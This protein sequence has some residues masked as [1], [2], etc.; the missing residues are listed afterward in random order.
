EGENPG[1]DAVRDLFVGLAD[2][3]EDDLLGRESAGESRAQLAAGDDVRAGAEIGE[4]LQD[5]E[6]RVRLG[7]VADQVRHR[8]KRRVE[9][10]VVL[11]DQRTAVDVDRRPDGAG[12]LR[13][14]NAVT[15][16]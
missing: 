10:A 3:G 14:E 11:F 4:D 13:E 2:S 5:R 16:Q 7:R 9:P 12:D 6:A 1:R 15:R 8:G